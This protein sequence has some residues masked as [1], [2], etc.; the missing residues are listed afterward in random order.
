M[1]QQNAKEATILALNVAGLL[2]IITVLTGWHGASSIVLGG[3][4]FVWLLSGAP[5]WLWARLLHR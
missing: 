5:I 3:V 1:V 2:A 4:A